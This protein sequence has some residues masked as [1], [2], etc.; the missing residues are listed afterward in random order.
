MFFACALFLLERE[1]SK[2]SD[3]LF[4][5]FSVLQNP[6][7]FDRLDFKCSPRL[8]TEREGRSNFH[9]KDG[10]SLCF[11]G[12]ERHSG[13]LPVSLCTSWQ[14]RAF[15]YCWHWHAEIPNEDGATQIATFS[16]STPEAVLA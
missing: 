6:L 13:I 11:E 5:C 7:G 9:I 15:R 3:F 10:I 14:S 2:L 4:L 16:Q 8:Q 12:I 1:D